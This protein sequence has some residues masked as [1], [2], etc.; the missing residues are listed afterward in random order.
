M[1]E[2]FKDFRI[3]ELDKETVKV[4][5]IKKDLEEIEQGL[6]A[7][8]AQ[9]SSK[10]RKWPRIEI[11]K[12]ENL[13]Q[14]PESLFSESG[15]QKTMAQTTK[16]KEEEIKAIQGKFDKLIEKIKEWE[17]ET[18]IQE[19]EVDKKSRGVEVDKAIKKTSIQPKTQSNEIPNKKVWLAIGLATGIIY[20][21]FGGI[22]ALLFPC[23]AV[24]LGIVY[25]CMFNK[26]SISEVKNPESV[27][28]ESKISELVSSGTKQF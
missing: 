24:F 19:E 12:L 14:E 1:V 7:I 8:L 21:L 23:S 4:S 11:F 9:E 20:L 17:N 6:E 22:T 13:V 16:T 3:T 5:L 28:T 18:I 15:I 25:N 2:E 10:L 27:I 26:N